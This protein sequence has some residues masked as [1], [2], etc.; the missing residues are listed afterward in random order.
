MSTGNG[1]L[2]INGDHHNK[3]SHLIS[4]TTDSCHFYTECI[5]PYFTCEEPGFALGYARKRCIALSVKSENITQSFNSET[6][7]SWVHDHEICLRKKL[8]LLVKNF[9]ADGPSDK[10]TCINFE[11]SAFSAVRECYNDTSEKFC[12]FESPDLE[13]VTSDVL[14]IRDLFFSK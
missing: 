9:S 12:S 11:N 2:F 5:E 13:G 6:L 3:C 1:V 8:L 4:N 14:H 7:Q 10:P